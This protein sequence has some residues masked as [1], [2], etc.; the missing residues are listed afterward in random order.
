MAP[1][2]FVASS[3]SDEG[4]CSAISARLR[5]CGLDPRPWIDVFAPDGRLILERFES[6]L[7]QSDF[8]IILLSRDIDGHRRIDVPV[9]VSPQTDPSPYA[10]QNVIFEM[11]ASFG[12]LGRH[13]TFVVQIGEPVTG[14][15]DLAGL[16][17]HHIPVNPSNSDIIA[18]CDRLRR[19]IDQA[20]ST[21][22]GNRMRWLTLMR[23]RPTFQSRVIN[24]LM[25]HEHA[26][27]FSKC[28]VQFERC[29]VVWGPPDSFV[30]FTVPGPREFEVFLQELRMLLQGLVDDVDSRMVFPSSYYS[31]VEAAGDASLPREHLIFL[32]CQPNKVEVVFR[33]IRDHFRQA[34]KGSRSTVR[35]VASG[36]VTGEDDVFLITRSASDDEYY[37][38]VQRCLQRDIAPAQ[39]LVKNTTSL[40]ITAPI[41]DD[42]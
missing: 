27:S 24:T 34:S 9:S 23:C 13:R 38:F 17:T 40:G 35:L 12:R 32:S 31:P 28:H 7:E 25:R 30:L 22:Q 1:R 11:G 8:C 18:L 16:L 21:Q 37:S 20:Q 6:E 14:L 10:N 39:Y 3:K 5:E 36:I 29:G 41:P 33:N 19:Q 42:R 4:V 2:I 15:S 26:E